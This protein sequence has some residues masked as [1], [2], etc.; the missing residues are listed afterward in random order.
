MSANACSRQ[1]KRERGTFSGA[2]VS[3]R[4]VAMKNAVL[5]ISA[6]ALFLGI[7]AKCSDKK[8]LTFQVTV[9]ADIEDTEAAKAG[10]HTHHFGSTVY[11]ASNSAILTLMYG[12]FKGA[13]EAERFLEWNV[14][15]SFKVLSQT[16]K[17]D[18]N[19]NPIEYRAE[20]VPQWDHSLTE[21]MWVVGEK[22]RWIF[23]RNPDDAHELEKQYR[24]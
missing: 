8:P 22:V 5:A 11:K 12:Y 10:F 2:V 19:G 17:T 18:P 6:A 15:K 13:D 16:T 9:M 3:F 7:P 24:R 21:V 23:A 1:L 20:L 4:S 14:K